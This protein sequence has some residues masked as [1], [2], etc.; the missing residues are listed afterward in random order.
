MQPFSPHRVTASTKVLLL[1]LQRN[2]GNGMTYSG[3]ASVTVPGMGEVS[4]PILAIRSDGAVTVIAIAGPLTADH[5]ADPLIAELREK[6]DG[7][8]VIPV[9]ELLVRGNLPAATRAVEEEVLR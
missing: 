1:D 8:A 9:N 4:V 7:G 6:W 2:T 5:P 3:D